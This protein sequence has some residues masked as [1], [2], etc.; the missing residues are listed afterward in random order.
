M[1]VGIRIS[2]AVQK[3]SNHARP[4]LPRGENQWRIKVVVPDIHMGALAQQLPHTLFIAL[5]SG[6]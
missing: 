3:N 2:A 5:Q 6:V 1:V 4:S